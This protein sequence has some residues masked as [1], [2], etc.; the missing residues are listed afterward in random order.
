[1]HMQAQAEQAKA[2]IVSVKVNVD[3][4]VNNE[5]KFQFFPWTKDF[6]QTFSQNFKHVLFILCFRTIQTSFTAAKTFANT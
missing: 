3:C 4:T 5:C 1:M 2:K 6:L